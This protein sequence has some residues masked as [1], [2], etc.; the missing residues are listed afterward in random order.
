MAKKDKKEK[1]SSKKKKVV[2]VKDTITNMLGHVYLDGVIPQFVLEPRLSILA[3]DISNTLLVELKS[4]TSKVL[5][6][7]I[8]IPNAERLL[9]ILEWFGDVPEFKLVK[10]QLVLKKSKSNFKLNTCPPDSISTTVDSPKAVTTVLKEYGKKDQYVIKKDVLAKIGDL[11]PMYSS[12][13]VNLSSDGKKLT[14]SIGGSHLEDDGDKFATTLCKTKTKAFSND[15]NFEIFA[16]IIKR[17]L[18]NDNLEEVTILLKAGFPITICFDDEA[19]T[20][21]WVL[22]PVDSDESD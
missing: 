3:A 10:K 19:C 4:K 17:C 7:S 16:K 22:A 13:L 5:D 2:L 15:Y 14:C 9:K 1:T 21:H 8:G 18:L 20:V 6:S 11:L 12:E